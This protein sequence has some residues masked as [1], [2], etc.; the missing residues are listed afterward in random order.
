L[1]KPLPLFKEISV[2][3]YR[4]HLDLIMADKDRYERTTAGLLL[5]D[6]QWALAPLPL[7]GYST[8]GQVRRI[9]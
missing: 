2:L 9:R 1:G 6:L 4:R 3:L 5:E 8:R 7:G